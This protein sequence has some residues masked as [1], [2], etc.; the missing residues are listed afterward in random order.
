[1]T[2]IFGKVLCAKSLLYSG[3]PAGGESPR[4]LEP[5]AGPPELSKSFAQDTF[6]KISVN[7]PDLDLAQS[8]RNKFSGTSRFQNLK[9]YTLNSNLT[10][11]RT[12]RST[13][14]RAIFMF[15]K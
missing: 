7:M 6:P 3:G 10:A 1:M 14:S 15:V 5:P 12:N 4:G 13:G 8:L 11:F 2:G 9:L